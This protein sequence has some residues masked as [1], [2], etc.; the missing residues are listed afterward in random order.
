MSDKAN[1]QGRE[2]G[3]FMTPNILIDSGIWALLPSS[4]KAVYQV[5]KRHAHPKSGLS[6]PGVR[7]ITRESGLNKETVCKA[8]ESLKRIGL[9]EKKLSGRR[10]GYRMS[11]RLVELTLDT[12]PVISEKCKKNALSGSIGKVQKKSAQNFVKIP[13][14]PDRSIRPVRNSAHCS[15]PFGK[16][17]EI[18]NGRRL[19]LKNGS[20]N[21]PPPS[22]STA[23]LPPPSKKQEPPPE[24]KG[25]GPN[26]KA[27]LSPSASD[28]AVPKK[29]VSSVVRSL[30]RSFS[31]PK[32]SKMPCGEAEF[33]ALRKQLGLPEDPQDE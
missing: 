22:Q 19:A 13:N 21:A 29:N 3:F 16:E 33:R 24:G 4:C 23:S 14:R 25:G 11:Y 5:L 27:D 15:E 17:K 28:F 7:T 8:T 6:Y 2:S 31:T 10:F 12:V 1:E 32:T 18:L 26:S 30:S 20:G 9:V